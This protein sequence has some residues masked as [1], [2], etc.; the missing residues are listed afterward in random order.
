KY[1]MQYNKGKD[2][3]KIKTKVNNQSTTTTRP[4]F[5]YVN[6]LTKD[7]GLEVNY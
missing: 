7:A 3:T 6:V 4:G 5:V 1:T 2:E